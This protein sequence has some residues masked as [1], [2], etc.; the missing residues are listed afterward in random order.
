MQTIYRKYRPQNFNEVFG[1]KPIVRVLQSQVRDNK[2]GHAYLFSGPRGTGKT[3]IARLL[4]KAVNC[5]NLKSGNPCKKCFSCVSIEKGRFLDLIEIDAAS[6]RGIDEI[7]RLRE[8]VSFSPSEGKYKVYIIDEV[9]MLT[10]DAFNALL[11]TLEEPPDHVIFI[12]ATT[13]SYKI[14]ATILSRCQRFNFSLASDKSLFRR[15][16]YICKLEGVDFSKDALIAIVRNA[17]GSFRDSESILEKVL[18]AIGVIKDK[19][20]DTEDIR[21]I[22]GLAED[23]EVQKFINLLLEKNLSESLNI[24]NQQVTSGVNLLQFLRQSLEYTRK[25]LIAKV[26]REESSF[27]LTDILKVV[28]E[29]SDAENKLRITQVKRLPIEVA[30]IKICSERVNGAE[31]NST[32]KSEAKPSKTLK[33]IVGSA[34]KKLPDSIKKVT[35]SKKT[36]TIDNIIKNWDLIVNKIKPFNHHL[37]AFYKKAKPVKLQEHLLILHVPFKFHKQRIESFNAQKI[38]KI[39]CKELFKTNLNCVCEV[40]NSCEKLDFNDEEG[41]S[42][43]NVVLEV[44]GDILE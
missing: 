37:S 36:A 31:N 27:L 42:N 34:I 2:V 23:K 33:K 8:R 11:K 22:L 18:G 9:H 21:E 25:L 29:L 16:R 24:F 30:I 13:E 20:V 32:Q 41:I 39:I 10:R 43:N 6:N 3:S 12:L 40:V 44:L 38:F 4:A 17:E 35:S 14:P 28:T 26:S 1:Q 7:R 19:R 15:L 5:E